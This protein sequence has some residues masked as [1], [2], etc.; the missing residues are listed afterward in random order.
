[1]NSADRSHWMAE[2]SRLIIALVTPPLGDT[3]TV[4]ADGFGFVAAFVCG[5]A[6]R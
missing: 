4:V 6:F 3:V 5:V 1:M 2:Q